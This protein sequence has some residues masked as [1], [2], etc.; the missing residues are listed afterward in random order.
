MLKNVLAIGCI[1][2]VAEIAEASVAGPEYPAP[3]GNGWS[4]GGGSSV[5]SGGVTYSY[6]GFHSGEFTDLYW[7]AWSSTTTSAG[8]DGVL[9]TLTFSQVTGNVATWTGTTN[10]YD[11]T[12]GRTQ[13]VNTQLQISITNGTGSWVSAASLGLTE[14]SDY[15][16]NTEG[17][18][19]FDANLLFSGNTGAGLVPLGDIPVGSSSSHLMVSSFSGGFYYTPP[20]TVPE[21]STIAIWSLLGAAGAVRC[22]LRRR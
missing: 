17:G 7:G 13:T 21:P 6:S 2:L 10:W 14:R 9:H 8:L 22:R 3:G 19:S 5:K 20:A 1:M 12:T 11:H 4:S 16:W 15:L 18:H